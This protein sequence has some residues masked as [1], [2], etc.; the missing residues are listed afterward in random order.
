MKKEILIIAGETSGDMHAA[1]VVSAI[2]SITSDF[3]FSGIGGDELKK[4]GADLIYHSKR[5]SFLG[6]IEVL[7]HLPFIKKVKR[8]I[9]NL[10]KERNIKYALLID[11]PGFN[12]S[13]AK[14]LKNLNVK[15]V[16]FISPQVWAWGKK[17][18][19][20][21]KRLVDKMLV[22]LP[23]E[24]EFYRNSGI[25]AEYVGH[26]LIERI[27]GY[28]FL[29]KDEF[30]GKFGLAR[31]KQI[32]L[33]QPGSRKQEI[34]KLFPVLYQAGLKIAK[35]NNLQIVVNCASGIN[36]SIFNS[37]V[38]SSEFKII[39]GHTYETIKYAKM[40][41]IKSGTSTLEAGLLGLPM[42]IVY[43]TNLLTYLIGRTLVELKNIGLINIVANETIVP[44]LIQHD[45]TVENLVELSNKIINNISY[46]NE[47]LNKL[48]LVKE[49][50]G[51][52]ITSEK[53][54]R[55]LIKEFA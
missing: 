12:L 52:V 38:N 5:M 17:R 18:V 55:I 8:D 2:N 15:I 35:E 11:Y 21:I 34:K 22:I 31:D 46:R 39:E 41:I 9:L 26:P 37:L 53:V 40:G 47:M 51:N 36:S 28:Q 20:K 24:S 42:I 32:L 13:I 45:V 30:F 23:F 33:I 3:F 50:L 44:E 43:K 19:S 16:Y 25:N 1:A 54:A 14:E 29:S 27:N 49:K 48:S 7:R 4:N 10:V 6:F